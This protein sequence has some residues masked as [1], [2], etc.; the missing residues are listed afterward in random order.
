MPPKHFVLHIH[1]ERTVGPTR[2][3]PCRGRLSDVWSRGQH[4]SHTHTESIRR[5][6]QRTFSAHTCLPSNAV[7]TV[8]IACLLVWRENRRHICLSSV[9]YRFTLGFAFSFSFLLHPASWQTEVEAAGLLVR[10]FAIRRCL[11]WL[12]DFL[13]TVIY[14]E[15]QTNFHT[16]KERPPSLAIFDNHHYHISPPICR[17]RICCTQTTQRFYKPYF[18]SFFTLWLY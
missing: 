17:L 4:S 16:E 5:I 3:S 13:R 8:S 2:C 18:S 12:I 10:S 6:W 14:Y 11:V 9:I 1:R 7:H 15:S